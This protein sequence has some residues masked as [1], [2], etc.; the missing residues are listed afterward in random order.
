L[1]AAASVPPQNN[2]WEVVMIVKNAINALYTSLKGGILFSISHWFI[3]AAHHLSRLQMKVI[4]NLTGNIHMIYL[5]IVTTTRCTLKCRHCIGDIPEIKKDEQYSISIEDYKIYLGN[6]LKNIKSLKLV[7]LLGGEP[8]LNKDID[9]IIEYTLE[10]PKIKQ[11]YLVTNATI[12]LSN[13]VVNVLKKYPQKSTVDISNYSTNKELASK[14]KINEIIEICNQN[15]ITVNCPDSYLWNPISPVRYH[16]RNTKENKKYYRSC[17]S[18]CVGMHKTPDGEAAV[19]P[20]LRSGTL[21]LRKIGNQTEGKDYFKL[22]NKLHKDD[23]INFH[24]NEDFD[25]CRY[26]NFLE[27]KKRQV[28]PALQR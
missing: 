7:R 9:K 14:L 23:I 21:F 4:Y 25:A 2:V 28:L 19:F 5:E 10:Q 16:K 15:N 27:D 22:D 13:E 8:L 6:L 1:V 12:M 20:C 18:I 11:V 17:A 26:C 24:L 3:Y